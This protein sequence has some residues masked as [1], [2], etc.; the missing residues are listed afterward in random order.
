MIWK[1]GRQRVPLFSTAESKLTEALEGMVMGDSVDVVIQE[2]VS[3]GY[4]KILK[5]D[6]VAAVNLVTEASGNWRTRH[7]RLRAIHVR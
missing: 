1:S 6:N 5:V 7:L 2:I 3:K 4:S